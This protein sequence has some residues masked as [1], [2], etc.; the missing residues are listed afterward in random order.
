MD[1]TTEKLKNEMAITSV[2][3]NHIIMLQEKAFSKRSFLYHRRRHT[4]RCR[5]LCIGGGELQTVSFV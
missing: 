3:G 1:L 5:F 2:L 4:R